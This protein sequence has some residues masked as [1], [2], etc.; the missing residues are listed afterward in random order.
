MFVTHILKLST[1]AQLGTLLG[2][3]SGRPSFLYGPWHCQTC[4]AKIYH[5][6]LWMCSPVSSFTLLFSVL[7]A[8]HKYFILVKVSSSMLNISLAAQQQ[9]RWRWKV[10]LQFHLLQVRGSF[11]LT[12]IGW[13]DGENRQDRKACIWVEKQQQKTESWRRVAYVQPPSAF[14]RWWTGPPHDHRETATPTGTTPAKQPSG[15]NINQYWI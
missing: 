11:H 1:R 12:G 14:Q 4:W 13:R 6:S 5:L 8:S 9:P 7:T 10:Q 3:L 2:D 15:N